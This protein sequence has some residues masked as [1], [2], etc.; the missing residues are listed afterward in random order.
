MAKQA[1]AVPRARGSAV[2]GV[3]EADVD[4]RLDQPQT[5]LGFTSGT[6][7]LPQGSSVLDADKPW[8]DSHVGIHQV[9]GC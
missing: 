2:P 6:E 4:K 5:C 7:L 1:R 3:G 8:V 9:P